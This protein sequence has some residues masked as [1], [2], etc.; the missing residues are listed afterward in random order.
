MIHL[1]AKHVWDEM[2][3]LQQLTRASM[4]SIGG[5]EQQPTLVV[6]TKSLALKYLLR[7]SQIRFLVG[8]TREKHLIYGICID[9]D[10][11]TPF[12]LWSAAERQDEIEAVERISRS[13]NFMLAMFNEAVVNIC[14]GLL[15]LRNSED[16][17]KGLFDNLTVAHKDKFESNESEIDALFE[18]LH[19]KGTGFHVFSSEGQP[20]WGP[21][22]CFYVT[23]QL[24]TSKL[25]LV[26][27]DEGGQ[28]EQL[29]AWITDSLHVGGV[30]Q[31]PNVQENT[32][33]ELC[34]LLLTHQFGTV[35]FESKAL[36]ILSR[37]DLPMRGKLSSMVKKHIEKALRQLTGA[38]KNLRTG[39]PILTRDGKEI[40]IEREQP[41]HCVVI[42]PDLTLLNYND[43]LFVELG[44]F[45]NKTKAFV[46][47]LDPSQ[48]FSLMMDS[49]NMSSRGK[50][51]TPM[52]AFD[53]L[54]IERFKSVIKTGDPGV[55]T[56][57]RFVS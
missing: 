38:C 37:P 16:D 33:R 22:E 7:T 41:P 45:A 55:V 14:S 2:M 35:M 18:K 24:H 29:A 9:D 44:T 56:L 11:K 54:L 27:A 5:G 46:N 47:I 43:E 36:A 17:V 25:D 52:M 1:P 4:A 26:H 49:N 32:P 3:S 51:T 40:K 31:N 23:N 48:L 10:P 12:L 19:S 21:N 30:H 13:E 57:C 42:I 6:K 34:D 15:T 8:H 50:M 39:T 53:Y 28:Q 20:Q